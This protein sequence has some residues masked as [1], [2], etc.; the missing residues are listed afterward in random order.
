MGN[1][2]APCTMSS[3][4]AG[5]DLRHVAVCLVLHVVA[6]EA[7]GM[8]EAW[9]M[10]PGL[11]VM[12]MLVPSAHPSTPRLAPV[13]ADVGIHVFLMLSARGRGGL[14]TTRMAFEASPVQ[15][16]RWSLHVAAAIG[17]SRSGGGP[18]PVRCCSPLSLIGVSFAESSALRF[19]SPLASPANVGGHAVWFVLGGCWPLPL[20]P[21]VV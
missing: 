18:L 7:F 15:L 11:A 16:A 13:L 4:A 9:P 1:G 17:E 8:S 12:F 5:S 19:C 20:A 2:A 14:A 21:S 10:T 3:G 6:L